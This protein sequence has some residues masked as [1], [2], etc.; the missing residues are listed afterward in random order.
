VLCSTKARP[1]G[2]PGT[3]A[4]DTAGPKRRHRYWGR[5]GEN[6]QGPVVDALWI[7][8]GAARLLSGSI[9]ARTLEPQSRP[10]GIARRAPI[11]RP[12]RFTGWTPGSRRPQIRAAKFITHEGQ[13]GQAKPQGEKTCQG[14]GVVGRARLC[15]SGWPG[16]GTVR[17]DRPRR[18]SSHSKR[19][20]WVLVPEGRCRGSEGR[21]LCSAAAGL[22][23]GKPAGGGA[24]KDLVGPGNQETTQSLEG[25]CRVHVAHSSTGP[26][27]VDGHYPEGELVV[28]TLGLPCNL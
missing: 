8:Q 24:R 16:I 12:K 22:A 28:K 7:G 10:A 9:P 15:G 6:Q 20:F 13:I 4:P 11:G 14:S 23:I 1:Y 17:R 26:P 5:S 2:C 18:V 21:A 3:R 19:S 25:R 27:F